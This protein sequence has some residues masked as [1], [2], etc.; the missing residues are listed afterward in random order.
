MADDFRAFDQGGSA[1]DVRNGPV[2]TICDELECR[3]AVSGFTP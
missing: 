3:L 1:G 2:T